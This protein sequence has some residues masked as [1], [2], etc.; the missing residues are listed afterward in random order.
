MSPD[1]LAVSMTGAR[2]RGS[3]RNTR[4]SIPMKSS[5]TAI[6]ATRS[7]I[8]GELRSGRTMRRSMRRP[9]PTAP[10]RPIAMPTPR[11]RFSP[12]RGPS[13]AVVMKTK[14]AARVPNSPW[15][16]LKTRVPL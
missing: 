9:T 6:V 2:F 10:A 11:G 14:Y 1:S 13:L 8:R 12:V 7:V 3:T 15:A 5:A 4:I 16:K